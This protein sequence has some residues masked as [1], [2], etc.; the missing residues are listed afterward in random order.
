MTFQKLNLIY[1]VGIFVALICSFIAK[2]IPMFIGG[3]WLIGIFI[4]LSYPWF[5]LLGGEYKQEMLE[6]HKQYILSKRSTSPKNRS[7]ADYQ[8][9]Q[10][11]NKADSSS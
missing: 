7:W 8:K 6:K 1:I 2:T 11:S 3:T 5:L 10:E 4:F 9:E